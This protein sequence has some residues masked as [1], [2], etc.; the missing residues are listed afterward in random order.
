[1]H[2][3]K[4]AIATAPGLVATLLAGSAEAL[5][6][7]VERREVTVVGEEPAESVVNVDGGAGVLGYFGGY[8]RV[9]PAWTV[10]VTANLTPRFGVQANYTGASNYAYAE[11]ARV[12]LTALDGDVR[13]NVLRPDAFLQPFVTAG[14]GW[15]GLKTPGGMLSMIDFPFTAGA[16]K[17]ISHG[18]FKLGARFEARPAVGGPNAWGVLASLGGRF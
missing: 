8:G 14:V 6:R 1:V 11:D 18:R 17:V 2:A 12:L 4:L 9:G 16:D 13:F 10:G 5:P 15:E 3:V 7:L